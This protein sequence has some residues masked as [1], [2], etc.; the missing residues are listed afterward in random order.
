MPVKEPRKQWRRGYDMATIAEFQIRGVIFAVMVNAPSAAIP[1]EQRPAM[2]ERVFSDIGYVEVAGQEDGSGIS[3]GPGRIA[4]PAPRLRS[5]PSCRQASALV[6]R[7]LPAPV[8]M[9]CGP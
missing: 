2:K 4:L 3:P 9:G 7:G 5:A 6:R 1:D 8:A